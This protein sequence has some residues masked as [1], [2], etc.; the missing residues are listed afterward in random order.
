M[1]KLFLFLVLFLLLSISVLAQ[2]NVDNPTLAFE[3][4]VVREHFNTKAE[5][6]M[7]L[8]EKGL[9]FESVANKIVLNSFNEFDDVIDRK[10]NKF[11]FKIAFALFGV[12]FFAESFWFFIRLYLEKKKL[13][14]DYDFKDKKV[15]VEPI[16]RANEVVKPISK[17]DNPLP[18]TTEKVSETSQKVPL[19]AIPVPSPIV[20]N[21]D[22]KAKFMFDL[23]N[24]KSKKEVKAIKKAHLKHLRNEFNIAKGL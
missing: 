22:V 9:E 7:L 24:A 10:L 13:D 12:I 20:E 4:V 8:E 23:M 15:V 2:S 11:I 16:V 6:K 3:K 19:S 18:S 14:L 1:K 17:V 21:S 5:F